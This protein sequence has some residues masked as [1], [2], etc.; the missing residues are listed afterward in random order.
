MPPPSGLRSRA[1]IDHPPQFTRRFPNL[2]V[3]PGEEVSFAYAFTP[4]P[5]LE[6][7]EWGVVTEILYSDEV[8]RP[9]PSCRRVTDD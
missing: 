8:R 5:S 6:P 4:D 1:L 7:R 2:V 9:P 3:K